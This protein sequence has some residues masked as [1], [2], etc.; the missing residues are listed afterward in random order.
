MVSKGRRKRKRER[1][2]MRWSGALQVSGL[3]RACRNATLSNAYEWEGGE[4]TCM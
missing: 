2:H 1:E 3:L 4:R